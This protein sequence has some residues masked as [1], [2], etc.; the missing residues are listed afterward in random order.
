M[1]TT[2]VTINIADNHW[3]EKMTDQDTHVDIVMDERIKMTFKEAI[4]HLIT[5]FNFAL[6]YY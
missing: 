3:Y 4:N 1:G 5:S 2:T 6:C